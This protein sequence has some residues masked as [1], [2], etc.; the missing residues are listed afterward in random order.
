MEEQS[1]EKEMADIEIEEEKN[2][3]SAEIEIERREEVE[4]EQTAEEEE[5]LAE[6]DA[7]LLMLIPSLSGLSL[8]PLWSTPS[9]MAPG[10]ESTRGCAFSPDGLCVLLNA[11]DNKLR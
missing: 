9:P 5:E 11:D 8:S 3:E 2:E 7:S 6:E 4:M 10:C 1:T